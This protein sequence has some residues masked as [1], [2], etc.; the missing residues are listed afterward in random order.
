MDFVL[1]MVLG[2]LLSFFYWRAVILK[3]IEQALL[4]PSKEIEQQLT[5]EN[6]DQSK[7]LNVLVE[8]EGDQFLLYRQDTNNFVMQGR[9]LQDFQ[10]R[11]GFMKIDQMSIVNGGSAAAKALVEISEK[12]KEQSENSNNQ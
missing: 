8:Q 1:G 12:Q 7:M 9:C 3:A 6:I 11:L 4:T 10:Q 2:A 5:K